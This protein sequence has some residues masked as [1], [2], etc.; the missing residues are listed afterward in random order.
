[1]RIA[2]QV[3]FL[4][5]MAKRILILDDDKDIL[6]FCSIISEELGLEVETSNTTEDIV[7]QV[8]A[9]S[10]DIILLDN[11]MPG[12]GGLKSIALLKGDVRFKHIPIIFFSAN[13]D[14]D[15]IAQNSQADVYLKKPFDV[16]ELEQVILKQLNL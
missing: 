16:T 1:M 12:P 3:L 15:K 4:W 9:K 8:Q 6:Y 11:W 14:F 13:N 7:S 2:S 5:T 10:P